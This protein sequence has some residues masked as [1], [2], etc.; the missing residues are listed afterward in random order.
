VKPKSLLRRRHATTRASV[1]LA[2]RLDASN[3][4]ARVTSGPLVPC[5]HWA[6]YQ[7]RLPS[8]T[9]LRAVRAHSPPSGPMYSSLVP[10][11][12][13]SGAAGCDT[14]LSMP[15]PIGTATAVAE[16]IALI[17]H[18]EVEQR[19]RVLN[20]VSGFFEE[21]SSDPPRPVAQSWRASEE[22]AS[23]RPRYA[24]EGTLSPKQFLLE[25]RPATD[26]E[27]MACLAY[28][29]T[30]YREKAQFKTADLSHLNT[31]AA[32]DRFSNPA[33]ASSNA[34]KQGYLA[35]AGQ[36]NRQLS[37]IG[38]RY[39]QALPDRQAAR[40]LLADRRKGRK[41]SRRTK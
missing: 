12:Y 3:R 32:Q 36:G 14:F 35:H 34:I 33:L 5:A 4:P 19:R 17:E 21:P 18:L 37:A 9:A 41:R 22:P 25:K 20:A 38:E 27:R 11:R 40:A 29:L 13:R 24:T 7:G 10:T 23:A 39:V 31:E 28:Y 26:V 1:V 6:A 30:H 8:R 2:V 16:I 15:R